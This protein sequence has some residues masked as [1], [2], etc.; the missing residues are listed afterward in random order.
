MK[1]ILFGKIYD[2][3]ITTPRFIA[4]GVAIF[5]VVGLIT[6][7]DRDLIL[8]IA[9]GVLMTTVAIDWSISSICMVLDTDED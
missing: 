6:N 2:A 8:A 1:D 5:V 4:L 7:M 9:W 3:L